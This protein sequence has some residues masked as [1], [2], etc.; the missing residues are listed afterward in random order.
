MEL[1]LRQLALSSYLLQMVE[2]QLRLVEAQQLVSSP[3]PALFLVLLALGLPLLADRGAPPFCV[4]EV[5]QL[6]RV[7]LQCEGKLFVL[8]EA[9]ILKNSCKEMI[10][11]N[12]ND[13]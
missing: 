5:Y 4:G 11:G 7:S 6:H 13:A 2:A 8:A 3:S 1:E 12:L 9:T 10:L